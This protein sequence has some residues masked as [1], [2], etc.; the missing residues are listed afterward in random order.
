MSLWAEVMDGPGPVPVLLIADA[1]MSGVA[2]PEEFVTA[3]ARRH[4]VIRYDH[5][6]TGR[7][8]AAVD[9]RVP[10]LDGTLFGGTGLA[11]VRLDG[12]RRLVGVRP[13]TTTTTAAGP[14]IRFPALTAAIASLPGGGPPDGDL[15]DLLDAEEDVMDVGDPL[16]AEQD[17]D[18]ADL[19]DDAVAVLDAVG[20]A[21]A[22]VV[23]LGLGGLLTQLLLLDHPDRLASATLIATGPLPGH[24]GPAAPGPTSAVTRLWAE[25]DDPRDDDGELAWRLAE[26]RLMHGEVLPF[27]AAAFRARDDRVVA[28][29]GTVEPAIRHRRL[30]PA[31]ARGDELAGVTVP[32]L[33]V[34]APE[35]PVRPPPNAAVLA[36]LLNVPLV[37]VPGLGHVVPPVA[38]GPLAA[39]I[40]GHT[41]RAERVGRAECAATA[42]PDE[43]DGGTDRGGEALISHPFE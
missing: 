1:D 21:R 41:A 24:A 36:A 25:L 38:A 18:A 32:A 16:D 7:S 37:T 17:Y 6:D 34:E 8:V 29:T 31:P 2:W 26:H 35:D 43:P 10:V 15:P 23:G 22:H 39:A 30:G 42:R 4:P 3:L 9:D 11:G 12:I 40:L 20:A 5:R 14:G 33:V 27:D 28:H 13:R 19:A